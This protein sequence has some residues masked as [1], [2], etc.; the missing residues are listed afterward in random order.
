MNAEK[1]NIDPELEKLQRETFGYFLH[2]AMNGS[3]PG[4]FG[5]WPPSPSPS[6]SSPRLPEQPYPY[7][8]CGLA[9]AVCADDT[10][11]DTPESIAFKTI[12]PAARSDF[13]S[14]SSLLS[15]MALISQVSTISGSIAPYLAASARLR[16][17]LFRSTNWKTGKS[18][19]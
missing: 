8:E 5:H 4:A 9:F 15:C 14:K 12:D 11:L 6:P 17:W 10:E 7:P 3:S 1:L 13:D 18:F 19:F 2:E 16:I